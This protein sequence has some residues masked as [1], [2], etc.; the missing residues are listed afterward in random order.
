MFAT[1]SLPPIDCPNL[2]VG[3]NHIKSGVRF[4]IT[5]DIKSVLSQKE[6]V[7]SYLSRNSKLSTVP[8]NRKTHDR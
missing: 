8:A 3:I 7:F 5:M 6:I 1:T 2:I 4:V